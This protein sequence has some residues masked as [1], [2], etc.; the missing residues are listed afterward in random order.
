[1]WECQSPQCTSFGLLWHVS[2]P[3]SDAENMARAT[4]M[5]D[6]ELVTHLRTMARIID[7]QLAKW[8]L[9]VAAER[10]ER[11]SSLNSAMSHAGKDVRILPEHRP[12]CAL[13][14][15]FERRATDFRIQ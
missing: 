15:W 11:H 9:G 7:G 4:Q 2:R 6:A 14:R 8:V 5:T 12:R 10:I 13:A 1:V 3:Y